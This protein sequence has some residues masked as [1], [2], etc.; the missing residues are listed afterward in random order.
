MAYRAIKHE[1]SGAHGSICKGLDIFDRPV[2][3]KFIGSSVGGG[4]EFIEH[5][6]RAL[7]RVE[8]PHVVKVI[9]VENVSNPD[10]GEIGPAIIMEWIDGHTLEHLLEGPAFSLEDVRRIGFGII[11]GMA[12][13]HAGGVA[14]S[15]FHN[16]NVMVGPKTVKIIDILYYDTLAE[17]S[18]ASRNGKYR[19]D[20]NH[21]RSMLATVMLHSSADIARG[22][23]FNLSLTP[24]STL[25]E[26]RLAFERATHDSDSPMVSLR[27]SNSLASKGTI[28][29]SGREGRLQV[30]IRQ[31]EELVEECPCD[32]IVLSVHR[33]VRWRD[34]V[35]TRLKALLGNQWA[36]AFM[37]HCSFS[38]KESKDDLE[39]IVVSGKEWL[40]SKL[41]LI[42]DDDIKKGP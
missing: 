31:I 27:S 32:W 39:R 10:T 16:R 35:Q 22:T 38:G 41:D 4:L 25:E 12:A 36:S 14:H 13:I 26:I 21:L 9:T 5:Q 37:A 33:A 15:D 18:D 7:V 3:I 30:A 29:G 6:A 23:S 8:N 17:M 1:Q 2:A 11:D 20:R 34:K 40:I 24:N 28:V 42:G 19:S